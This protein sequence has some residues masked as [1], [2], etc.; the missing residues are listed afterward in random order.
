MARHDF[1]GAITAAINFLEN[2]KN[3]N[4]SSFIAI[5]GMSLGGYYAARAVA[6]EKRIDACILFDV[7]TD[8]WSSIV[9]KNPQLASHPDLYGQGD[10]YDKWMLQNGLWV[11]G[12]HDIYDLQ[13]KVKSFNIL[14]VAHKISCP[15]LL[16]YG[17]NDIFVSNEQLDL[18]KE[19]LTCEYKEVIFDNEFGGQE[20]C[21]AGNLPLAT[22]VM[23][24][25]L[26]TYSRKDNL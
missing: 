25:W 5:M 11:F 16:Q 4:D 1:E 12:A 8:V 22:Q 14:P 24:D 9:H 21:R 26:D 10:N 2:E 18:L 15:I 23:F 13:K 6:M 7:F 17:T 3:V 19:S 20:H